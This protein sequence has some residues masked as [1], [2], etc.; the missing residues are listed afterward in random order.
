MNVLWTGGRWKWEIVLFPWSL[1]K[2][3]WKGQR[4]PSMHHKL[5]LI[6]KTLI[7]DATTLP[8][9]I[10]SGLVSFQERNCLI[11]FK[12]TKAVMSKDHFLRLWILGCFPVICLN[13]QRSS[14]LLPLCL[15]SG[16]NQL[17]SSVGVCAWGG[18]ESNL[19]L[20]GSICGIWTTSSDR[21]C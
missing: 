15:D 18:E 3:N 7:N 5:N 19:P 9:N 2:V 1:N 14:V 6:K 12:A 8:C 4:R 17:L 21:C 16:L 20:P 11:P 10:S 13:R